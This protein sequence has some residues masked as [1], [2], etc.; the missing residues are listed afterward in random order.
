MTPTSECPNCRT[1]LPIRHRLRRTWTCR[2]CGSSL[3][4]NRSRPVLPL[5]L[6]GAAYL[7][8]VY[9]LLTLLVALAIPTD[10]APRSLYF[11]LVFALPLV[12]FIV[13]IL[14][15]FLRRTVIAAG[16]PPVAIREPPEPP[17]R[18]ARA[19]LFEC[20]NCRTALPFKR[21]FHKTWTC[22]QCGSTLTFGGVKPLL[23]R[24]AA[25][26]I[27]VVVVF[28]LLSALI[29]AVSHVHRTPRWFYFQ[30]PLFLLVA[31]PFVKLVDRFMHRTVVILDRTGVHCRQCGYDLEGNVS[32]KCPECG[33]AAELSQSK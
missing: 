31:Y 12:Y 32:G 23:P 25:F 24:F 15:R 4:F 16:S 28:P 14:D 26:A 18:L 13:R 22:E 29:A 3:A 11:N 27:C 17:G 7:L 6:A 9:P 30:L 2:Q 5:L 21:R 19:G 33:T 20:P 1:P 8:I 10:L